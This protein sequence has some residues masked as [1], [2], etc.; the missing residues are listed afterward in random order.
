[1]TTNLVLGSG[2]AAAGVA[3]RLAAAG[4]QE[5]TLLDLGGRLEAQ[6]AAAVSRLGAGPDWDPADLDLVSTQPVATDRGRLPQKRSYGSDYP[7]RD[8]GQLEG[9]RAL[10]GGNRSVVSSAY[11]GFS[12]VWGAQ[13]MPFS[14]ATFARWPIGWADVEAHY[15]AVLR[16]VPLAAEHDDLAEHFPLLA[17]AAPL[18]PLAPRSLQVL[19]RAERHRAGLRRRG[20]TVGRA[21]L[22]L[23]PRGCT[24]CGLC[25]TGCP[26][27]LVYSAAQ[28]IDRLAAAGAL[29]HHRGLL[30]HRVGQD[31]ATATVVA[32]H[33]GSGRDVVFR[34]DRV[35]VACGGLGTTRLVLGSMARPPRQLDLAESVQFAVPFLSRV[36][37]P[38]PRRAP[39]PG[40][41]LN[42][43][44]VLVD[45][46]GTGYDTSQIHCYPYNP[47][48]L[49]ALPR[50]LRHRL[51]D[52]LT[53]QLLRRLTV[54]LGYLP[55]W[56]SPTVRV[57]RGGRSEQGL[58][59]ITLAAGPA[60]VEGMFA[61]VA[62]R[63]VTAA[64]ALDLWPVLAATEQ[65]AA[66]KSYHFGSAFPHAADASPTTTDR[67][68]RLP[69]WDRVHLVDGSVLPSVPSTTFTLTV[70]A[71]AHRIAE[72]VLRRER[73][74]APRVSRGASSAGAA[75]E[76]V[77]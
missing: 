68:G 40:F 32:R 69:E 7:F 14:K 26:Y 12:T 42:Q 66:G 29:R 61:Q 46:D 8:L 22:A 34:A 31:G 72:E 49:A 43:F 50:P 67:L 35:F 45:L 18:P 48:V 75:A 21:R 4:D 62:R 59:E 39:V 3:L 41:S 36:P 38:D 6:H 19:A 77:G 2:P 23:R 24:S 5:V 20:V 30:V 33:L 65:A 70:M 9:I 25:L 47:A 16:E 55:S 11:G 57:S 51:A 56:A 28:T 53:G 13:V 60:Q 54:G 63:L 17:E 1:M 15:R 10:A 37:V 76:V 52:P 44:N 74:P 64:P 58:P 27:G 71:N 73:V